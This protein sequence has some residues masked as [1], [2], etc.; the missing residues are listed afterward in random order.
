M[1]VQPCLRIGSERVRCD[2]GGGGGIGHGY[3]NILLWRKY[4]TYLHTTILLFNL[5]AVDVAWRGAGGTENLG[6]DLLI[7]GRELAGPPLPSA[8]L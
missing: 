3:H 1:R 6:F 5:M 8:A 2:G 4:G 7:V